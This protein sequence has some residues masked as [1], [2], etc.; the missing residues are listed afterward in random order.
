METQLS[1]TGRFDKLL[2]TSDASEFSAGA[3]RIAIGL[4]SRCGA[5]LS[6]M[7]MVITNPEYEAIA[8]DRVAKA[9]EEARAHLES[10]R[11]QAAQEGV[12]C[13]VVLRHGEDPWPVI[14]EEAERQQVDAIV[15]GRQ[16]RRGI[17]RFMVGDA[18]VKVIGHAHCSVLVAPRAAQM[19]QRRILTATDGSRYSDA[20]AAAAGKLARTCSLPVTVMSV[21]ASSH[22]D[23]RRREAGE[24]V[25][26]I[27]TFLRTEGVT[28]DTAVVEGR[29]DAAIIDTASSQ[30]AD[31]IVVGSHGRTGL[32][33]LLIGSVS[34]RV[35]GAASGP[36]LIA[37]A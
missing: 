11:A 30:G 12:E 15:M 9:E 18:T 6:A 10:I 35:I 34:E 16:G 28:V 20:A 3:L 25:E 21:F 19:W 22:S 37:K 32:E 4:A 14:V 13:D 26:R 17:A 24:A 31:L 2:V 23:V 8:P 1:P 5:K 33:R 29:P 7:T 27:A 36:V